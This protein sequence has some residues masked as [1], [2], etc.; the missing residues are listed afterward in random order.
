MEFC[1]RHPYPLEALIGWKPAIKAEG[2]EEYRRLLGDAGFRDAIKTEAR[3]RTGPPNRFSY[4]SLEH[5]TIKIGRASCR[6][7]V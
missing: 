7:R 1:L 2:S 5:M 3:G 4:H 6:E